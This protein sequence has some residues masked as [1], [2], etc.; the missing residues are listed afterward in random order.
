MPRTTKP[1]STRAK[2]L[3]G[4]KIR[5]Y[6]EGWAEK[7]ANSLAEDNPDIVPETVSHNMEQEL[8]ALADE[9]DPE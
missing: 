6:A 8:F 1:G 5:D 9:L 4:C 3:V 7:F 2:R